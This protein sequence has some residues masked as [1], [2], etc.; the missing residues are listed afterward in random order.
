MTR[1]EKLKILRE[2]R[3]IA[4]SAVSLL[5]ESEYADASLVS[6]DRMRTLCDVLA[7]ST[8]CDEIEQGDFVE[9][10]A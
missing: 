5:R 6:Y 3:D 2:V 7:A 10:A 4:S 1:D 9:R 8:A